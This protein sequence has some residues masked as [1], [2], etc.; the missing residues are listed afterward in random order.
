MLMIT[1]AFNDLLYN[2]F[3]LWYW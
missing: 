2:C 1:I 3:T